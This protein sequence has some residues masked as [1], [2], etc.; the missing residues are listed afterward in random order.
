MAQNELIHEHTNPVEL[1]KTNFA[2]L[3][4][5][6]DVVVATNKDLTTVHTLHQFKILLVDDNV[7]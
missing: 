5:L 3:F 7:T 6:K 1:L 4:V 2:I